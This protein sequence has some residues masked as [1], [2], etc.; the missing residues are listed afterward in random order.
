M[1]C[2]MVVGSAAEASKSTGPW[3]LARLRQPIR[4]EVDKTDGNLISIYY[5]GEPYNSKPTRVFAYLAFPSDAKGPSPAIV[6]VHGGAGRAF[7]EWAQMWAKRGY[8]AIAMDHFGNGPDGTRSADG[9]PDIGNIFAKV[10]T[11]DAWPYHAVADVIRAVSLLSAMPE[12]DPKRIG[13]TGV[14]W[15]GFVTCIAAGLD[16]RIKAA[17]PIY[18]CGFLH[19]GSI[20]METLTAM[21]AAQRANWVSNFDPSSY[22]SNAKMPMLFING[23][24]DTCFW[25]DSYQKTYRLAKNRTLSI[26]IEMPHGQEQGASP[27]EIRIFMDQH[28]KC[29]QP[30]PK[31]G[32]MKLVGGKISV[33][34]QSEAG[35]KLA[36]LN[37]TTDTGNW[38]DRK[39][40]TKPAVVRGSSIEADLPGARPIACFISLTDA[41]GALVSTEHREIVR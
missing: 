29:G 28:L 14:S 19:E 13:L 1:M 17:A 32:K 24:N 2:I 36:V 40:I 5:E 21:D 37:Y 6:L 41:R 27:E 39:W 34:F 38:R 31:L 15:G 7:P 8:V 23:T 30:L 9:G 33:G 35:A 16:D 20:W 22:L 4:Y 25:L 12:V 26:H 11:K 10:D 18:G 3:D